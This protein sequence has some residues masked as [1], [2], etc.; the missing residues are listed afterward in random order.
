MA[1]SRAMVAETRARPGKESP[2]MFRLR[3]LHRAALLA[4]VASLFLAPLVQAR[5]IRNPD[6]RNHEPG[7]IKAALEALPRAWNLLRVLWEQAGSSLDPF[8]EPKPNTGSS[9]DP[10]GNTSG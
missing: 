8:G 1:L 6:W 2:Y 4:L 3:I 5:D 9:P 10:S 7:I